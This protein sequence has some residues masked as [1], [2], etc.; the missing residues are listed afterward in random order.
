MNQS[1]LAHGGLALVTTIAAALAAWGPALGL[2]PKNK[3]EVVLLAGDP[4]ALAS[5]RWVDRDHEVQLERRD[6]EG[7]WVKVSKK[8]KA[9]GEAEPGLDVEGETKEFPGSDRARELVEELVPFTAARILGTID[10]A[11][12][13]E[14]G[15]VEP[16]EQLLLQIAGATHTILV[17]NATYGSGDRYAQLNDQVFLLKSSVLTPLRG[18]ANVLFERRALPV[19]QG[20]IRRVQV[21]TP[22]ATRE[23]IQRFGEDKKKAFY[24]DPAVPDEKLETVT[25]WVDRVLKLRVERVGVDR[26]AGE[27]A[28]VVELVN[29]K[30]SLGTL[31]LWSPASG[32]SVITSTFFSAP[33]TVTSSN[34]EAILRD[35]NAILEEGR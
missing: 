35:L 30:G 9:A 14:F 21:K 16:T 26:P 31:E 18:G 24:A 5:V 4:R 20:T 10:E 12:R 23:V 28:L 1:L 3:D 19:D 22:D 33:A 29:G 13:R 2:D 25:N 27:P 34:A 8:T 11:Q 6:A 7:L 15:L 17:G 32:Q